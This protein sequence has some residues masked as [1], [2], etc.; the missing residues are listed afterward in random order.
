MPSEPLVVCIYGWGRVLRLY[1]D[2]I[3]ANG[4]SYAL[5][6]LLHVRPVY[7]HVMGV[8]SAR[9]ELRFRE[10]MLVLRGI[11]AVDDAC[12][13]VEYL[14]DQTERMPTCVMPSLT[15]HEEREDLS[16][17]TY[18]EQD[19]DDIERRE[20]AQASTV[21][22]PV[23]VPR[24][25][26][27]RQE[28]RERKLKRWRAERSLREHGFDVESLAQ[29]LREGKLPRVEVPARLLP[30]EYAHYSVEATLCR[31][32]PSEATGSKCL[33]RDH[34]TLILTN[35]RMIYLGRKCQLVL[36]YERLLHVSRLRGAVAFLAEHWTRREV[37]ELRRPLE[38]TM[39]LQCIL[40]RYQRQ[41]FYDR[42]IQSHDYSFNLADL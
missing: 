40:Q 23:K 25:Q 26:R 41:S 5:A 34:G 36:S 37:F 2:H 11:A 8:A 33:P 29:R 6:D 30:D 13:I 10:K 20:Y 27:A 3:D 42:V 1:Q 18:R 12:R 9:L 39:Y 4:T 14:N 15:Q 17:E 16:D 22:V 32:P 21:R 35:R 19:S 28:Q 7:R 38:C 24:W 31:E